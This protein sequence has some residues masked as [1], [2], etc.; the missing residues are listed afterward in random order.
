MITP[1]TVTGEDRDFSLV[2]GDAYF[3]LEGQCL[4]VQR[5][6][7]R[8]R[9]VAGHDRYALVQDVGERDGPRCQTVYVKTSELRPGS[10]FC[11]GNSRHEVMSLRKDRARK[12][13]I[14]ITVI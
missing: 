9:L 7:V 1:M 10:V 3:L 11:I 8:K 6:R 12:Q 13:S 2:P 14:V 5:L 4:G